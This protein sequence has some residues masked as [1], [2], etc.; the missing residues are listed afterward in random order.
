MMKIE[1]FVIDSMDDL[2]EAV[3]SFGFL[4]FFA[5]SIEGFSLEEHITWDC[6]YHSGSGD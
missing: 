1:D 3:Q 4:P 6:W 2:I 5:N